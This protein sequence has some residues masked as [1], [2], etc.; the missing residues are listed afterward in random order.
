MKE[1]PEAEDTTTEKPA[2]TSAKKGKKTDEVTEIS[3][4]EQAPE[5]GD[6]TK[7]NA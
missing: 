7:E 5:A 4:D 1:A 3:E 2:K 6:T